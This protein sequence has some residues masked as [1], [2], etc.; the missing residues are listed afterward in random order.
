MKKF[1]VPYSTHP[2]AQI[3][4]I[5]KVTPGTPDP[6]NLYFSLPCTNPGG[7]L[8]Q[9]VLVQVCVCVHM[10]VCACVNVC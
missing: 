2:G 10:R 3:S 7:H 5:F 4:E 1:T 6:V 9:P 8:A